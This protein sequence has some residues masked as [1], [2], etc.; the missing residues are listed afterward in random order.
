MH[1]QEKTSVT[2]DGIKSETSVLRLIYPQWQGGIVDHWM[3]DIVPEDASKGYF[4][5]A[6]LLKML[7]PESTAMTAE[8]PV[9]LDIRDRAVEEGISARRVIVKQTGAALDI[10]R[11]NAPEKIVTLGGECSVSVVPFT[12]LAAKYPDDVA[13]VWLDA[14]PDVNL[15]DD[16]YKGYHAMALTACLGMGDE[17]IMRMLPGKVAAQN[18]LIVG[19]RSWDAGMKQRQKE[20]GIKGLS[21]ADVAEDSKAILDWLKSTGVSKVLVH[22]D[23]D[24]LDPAEIIAGVGVEPNGMKMAEA[25][26]VINDIAAHYDLVG[27][28]VAE[29]MPRIAIRMKRMLDGLP[30]LKV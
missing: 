1:I 12:Y 16:E 28:T 11:G 18:A 26:R 6:Q 21:P 24:V 10:V 5:G 3:P 4:L 2:G 30:L 20:L 19:L 14:H 23:L 29:F 15:P 17:G 22:F 8:V 9:S 7:A 27:L 25:I 13:I